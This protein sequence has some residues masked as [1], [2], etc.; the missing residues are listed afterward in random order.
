M[1]AKWA[2]PHWIISSSVG[3]YKL[4]QQAVQFK[5]DGTVTG[6]ES[7]I[8][9]NVVYDYTGEINP[10]NQIEL[11]SNNEKST[12]FAYEKQQ[13]NL[14][15]YELTCIQKDGDNCIKEIKGKMKWDL[16]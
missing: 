14:T 12:F 7:Y 16:K 2:L 10:P 11:V 4:N 1:R 5:E 9:Y 6:L 8:S 13:N 15:I 3:T